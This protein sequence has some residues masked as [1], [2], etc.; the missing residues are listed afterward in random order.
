MV[1]LRL[2]RGAARTMREPKQVPFDRC[3]ASNN[4]VMSSVR[5]SAGEAGP[6]E[7]GSGVPVPPDLQLPTTQDATQSKRREWT[8]TM[9]MDMWLYKAYGNV[10]G[11]LCSRLT[12]SG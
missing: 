7:G 11:C 5:P 1:G 2:E 8:W 6:L 3:T 10:L 4:P 12:L 9:P